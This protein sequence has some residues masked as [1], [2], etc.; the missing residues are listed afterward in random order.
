MMMILIMLL[1]III[2]TVWFISELHFFL[3][4]LNNINYIV[5]PELQLFLITRPTLSKISLDFG[6]RRSHVIQNSVKWLCTRQ[7]PVSSIEVDV[8]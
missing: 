6:F 5:K 2:E 3:K 1:T 8:N 4:F 7:L